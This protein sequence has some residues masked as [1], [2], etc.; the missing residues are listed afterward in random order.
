VW[1]GERPGDGEYNDTI[2]LM[3]PLP[4]ILDYSHSVQT[5]EV[6]AVKAGDLILKNVSRNSYPTEA[7]LLTITDEKNEERFYK[8]G[9]HYYRVVHIKEKLVTWDIHIRKVHQDENERRS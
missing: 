1:D 9:E 5:T 7:E 2:V 6:G 3:D 8:V 4:G